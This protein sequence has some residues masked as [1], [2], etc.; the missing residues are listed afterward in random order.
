MLVIASRLAHHRDCYAIPSENLASSW[1]EILGGYLIPPCPYRGLREFKEDDD[2]I[3]VGR[4]DDV[5]RLVSIVDRQLLTVVTGASGVGKSSLI[6]AGLVPRLM[7]QGAWSVAWVRARVHLDPF[8]AV[9]I[10][11]LRMQFGYDAPA[12]WHIKWAADQIRANG[13]GAAAQRMSATTDGNVLLVLDQFEELWL[14][15]GLSHSRQRFI[16]DIKSIAEQNSRDTSVRVVAILRSDFIQ[17]LIDYPEAGSRL[18]RYLFG[19]SPLDAAA[20]ERVIVEPANRYNVRYSP[21]LPAHIVA[22]TGTGPGALPLL[23]FTLTQLWGEQQNHEITHDSYAATGPV[24]HILEKYAELA[25]AMLLDNTTEEAEVRQL[26]LK[27]VRTRTGFAPT[28]SAVLRG[29]LSDRQLQIANR[30]IGA[31]LLVSQHGETAEGIFE[32][33]HDALLTGWARMSRWISEDREFLDWHSRMK[34]LAEGDLLPETRLGEARK[35]VARRGEDIDS[36]VLDL[37]RRSL[38]HSKRGQQRLTAARVR[39]QKA[40]RQATV[41]EVRASAAERHAAALR[42]A[43]LSELT[44]QSHGASTSLSIALAIESLLRDPT[45]QG[46]LALRRA[47][48]G[49]ARPLRFLHHDGPVTSVTFS[50]DG[51]LVATGSDDGTA[52]I[53]DADTGAQRHLLNHDGPVKSIAFDPA[54]RLLAVAGGWP[55]QGSMQIFN[56][57]VGARLSRLVR[58]P[59]LRL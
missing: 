7:R 39:A 5:E 17:P 42:L 25:Y 8:D 48:A 47:L 6:R 20:L 43:S 15:G 2:Q 53:F 23:E 46:D 10:A 34:D 33:A 11:L 37:V 30:L 26:L 50:P 3:F 32:V 41:A 16:R 1:P 18:A 40:E 57:A 31:R 24:V 28:R 27:F 59:H 22:D 9:A 44:R 12:D 13:L 52:R 45:V 56:A 38:A 21:N 36:D 35:W 49:V 4:E 55:G 54:G 29:D 14:H 19:V 58:Q 51:H